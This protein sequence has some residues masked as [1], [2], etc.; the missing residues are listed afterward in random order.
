M[1]RWSGA[2]RRS[3]EDGTV[4]E[5]QGEGKGKA[6]GRQGKAKGRQTKLGLTSGVYWL[7]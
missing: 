6:R 3:W 5:G 4:R 2:C 1:E 7:H